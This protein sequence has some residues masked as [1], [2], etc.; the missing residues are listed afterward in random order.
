MT[1]KEVVGGVVVVIMDHFFHLVVKDNV[2]SSVLLKHSTPVQ[3]HKLKDIANKILQGKYF[4]DKSTFKKLYHSQNFIR[5]LG[6]GKVST[7][8]LKNNVNIVAVLVKVFF[9]YQQQRQQHGITSHHSHSK[10]EHSKTSDGTQ[11]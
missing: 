10:T 6:V 2:Q 8:S 1:L 9:K 11:S 3:M 5:R 4:L 7:S